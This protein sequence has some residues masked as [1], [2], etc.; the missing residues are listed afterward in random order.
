M[1]EP[2]V[3]EIR[4]CAANFAPRWWAF[5]DGQ[6]LAVSQNNALFSL[7]GT[8]YGGTA[9]PRSGCGICAADFRSTLEP[10]PGCHQKTS[11]RRVDL[12]L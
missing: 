5:C 1:S 7:L 10:A 12:R 8:I 4:I 2:F 3:G 6:L 11:A 9:A